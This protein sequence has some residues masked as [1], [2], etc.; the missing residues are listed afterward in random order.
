MMLLKRE[1]KEGKSEG[2][3]MEEREKGRKEG[4]WKGGRME[5][6]KGEGKDTSVKTHRTY[7]QPC[8]YSCCIHL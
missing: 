5:G 1:R 4:G 7:I 3:R 6:R 8:M 2:G